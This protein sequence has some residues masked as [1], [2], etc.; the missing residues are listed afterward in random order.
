MVSPYSKGD[1]V[2]EIV[3]LLKSDCDDTLTTK[4]YIIMLNY[5]LQTHETI[6]HNAQI[7]N[8]NLTSLRTCNTLSSALVQ[9]KSQPRE[10]NWAST[11]IIGRS[12]HISLGGLVVLD[13]YR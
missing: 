5:V 3:R 2:Q 11:M 9:Y 7:R 8:G 4:A 1:I 6:I 10:K 12:N 13:R